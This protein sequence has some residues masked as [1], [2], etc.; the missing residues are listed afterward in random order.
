[1]IV[2]NGKFISDPLTNWTFSNRQRLLEIPLAVATDPPPQHVLELLQSVVREHP[3]VSKEP[4][5]QVLFLGLSGGSANFTVRAW[6]NR[7]EDWSQTRSDLALAISS[8]L[9]AEK[10]AIH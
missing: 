10:I 9:V 4:P 6:T 7:F 2:P 5:P 8:A 3:A 1:M